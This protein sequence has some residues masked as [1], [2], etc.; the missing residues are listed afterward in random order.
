MF[1]DL[2]RIFGYPNTDYVSNLKVPKYGDLP[3]PSIMTR[4]GD[5]S[6]WGEITS[7]T[8]ADEWRT[9]CGA[10]YFHCW[11]PLNKNIKADGRGWEPLALFHVEYA[12]HMVLLEAN[13]NWLLIFS[14]YFIHSFLYKIISKLE[15]KISFDSHH[16]IK[17]SILLMTVSGSILHSMNLAIMAYLNGWLIQIFPP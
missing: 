3:R 8:E 13:I 2:I 14:K 7:E 9:I 1:G 12:G 15:K 11:F 17:L 6:R 4:D 16:L 10:H 5:E